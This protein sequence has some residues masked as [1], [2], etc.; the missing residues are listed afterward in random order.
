MRMAWWEEEA[1]PS[2]LAYSGFMDLVLAF[3]SWKIIMTLQMRKREK[4]GVAI[5]MIMGVL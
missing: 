4:I 1:D 2:S 3:L 5:A